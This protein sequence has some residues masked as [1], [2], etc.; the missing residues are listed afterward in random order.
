MT[1]LPIEGEMSQPHLWL[2]W[3][4]WF[5]EAVAWS[6]YSNSSTGDDTFYDLPFLCLYLKVVFRC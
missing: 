4:R 2:E 6:F 3:G 1:S 5:V